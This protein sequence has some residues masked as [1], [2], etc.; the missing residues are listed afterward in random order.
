LFSL[1]RSRPLDRDLDD[2][3]TAHLALQEAEFRASGMTP[4]AA[5]AAALREFGGVAQTM[6]EYR[7][8][9]GVP[10]IDTARRDVRY[11]V[12]GLICNPGF[13]ATAVLSLGLGIG[14]NTAIFSLFHSLM[15]RMLPVERPEEL[16][17]MFRTG[18]WGR[19]FVSY[20]LYQEIAKRSDLFVGVIG[21]SGVA[22]VR[23]TPRSGA[24]AEFTQRE[25]VTGNYFSLLA[26]TAALGRVF[27]EDDNRTPGAHPV[28]VISYD[29]WRNRYG[30][31]PNILGA[32]I[33]VAEKPYTIIG[34]AAAGFHGVEF[35]RR[36]EVWVPAMM[37][38]AGISNPN[39]WWIWVVARRRPEIP[40]RRVQAA[41]DVLMR[42]HLDALYPSGYDAGMRQRALGQRLE[43]RDAA[44]GL[45]LLR[46]EFSRPLAIL[47]AAV[48]LVLL[49]ACANV[50]NLLLARGAARRKEIAL[51]L[52]FGATRGRLVVQALTES[53]LLV[54]AGGAV[55]VWLAGW[56]QQLVIRFLPEQAG[57]PF[58]G[59]P[60]GPVLMFTLA[61]SAISVL[62]FGL[63][64]ALRSTSV[65]PAAGLRP[66][67]LSRTGPLLLR[68][69]LV[70]TQV[71]FSVVLVAMAALFGHNLYALRGVDLGFRNQN[72]VEFSLD[73]PH[74]LRSQERASIRQLAAQL[75]EIPGV[76]SASYGFPGPFLMGTSS[77]SIRVPGSERTSRDPVDVQ[78]A[79]IAPRYFETIGARLTTGREFEPSDGESGRKVAVVNEAF[80]REFLPGEQHPELR[81]LSFDSS[82]SGEGE[83]TFIVGVVRDI[84]HSGI[85]PQARPTVYVPIEQRASVFSPIMLVRTQ[86]PPAAMLPPIY[87]E[88]R[89]VSSA[90][91]VTDLRTLSSQVDDSIFEQRL[92]A[93]VGAFFGA[94]ALVLAAIGLYGVVAYGTARRTAEIGVRIALGARPPQVIWMILRDSLV[95]VAIGLGIGLPAALV[96]ARAVQS[97]LFDIR[98]GDPPAL[99]VTGFTLAIA[100]IVAAYLPARRAASLDPARVLRA[101]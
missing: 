61:I 69:A 60:S 12:R 54:I 53:L 32:R 71:A 91:V 77:D 65:D 101:E 33:L 39:A 3:I 43:V 48:G 35:E 31:D 37:A 99:V 89:R 40:V 70:V 57:N 79:N 56:G 47:L 30:A 41:I 15:L 23:F 38:D 81:R 67:G 73:F 51:R 66:G 44:I 50:A 94:L 74:E 82:K 63:G 46:E 7:E 100:G 18:G 76:S 58:S 11:A 4:A 16:V 36:A 97:L 49:A 72:V 98:P 2:E 92:L 1:F 8:R 87:R 64:P 88:L 83:P 80:V 9:R 85:Q 10:W 20:P 22:K 21:R 13:T 52:S 34:V 84:R 24:R 14:A 26:V 86:V 42:Q 55:G 59:G 19:G 93:A 75:A 28:A 96:S 62:L 78:T 90:I 27:T 25:F 95:L 6:E 5:R 17:S 45:S 29:L 68:R